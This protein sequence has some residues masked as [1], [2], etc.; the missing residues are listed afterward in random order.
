MAGKKLVV[1]MLLVLVAISG[2]WTRATATRPLQGDQVNAA[3]EPSSGGSTN[4]APPAERPGH[5]LPLFEKKWQQPCGKTND[6]TLHCP[7]AAP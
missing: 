3:G 6:H 5:K 7:P 1:A 2:S 4:A